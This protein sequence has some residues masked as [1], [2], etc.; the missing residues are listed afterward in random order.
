MK[1]TKT[2]AFMEAHITQYYASSLIITKIGHFI[3]DHL[4][5]SCG[6]VSKPLYLRKLFISI[7]IVHFQRA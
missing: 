2:K 7:Q 4:S 6:D 3:L 5:G 1:E